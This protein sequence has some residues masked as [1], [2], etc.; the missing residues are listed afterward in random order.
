MRSA[1]EIV[2]YLLKQS[3]ES[4]ESL[5]TPLKLQKLLYYAQAWSLVIKS[6]TLFYED[7]EA[8]VHGPVIPPVYRRY[9]QYG[10]K[11][12]PQENFFSELKADEID[13]LNMVWMNYGK[14]SAKSLEELTHSE[15]PWINAR[16]G[17]RLDQLSS[18]KIS[19]RDMRNYYI[20]FIES[21]QP[22]K[23]SSVALQ[24]RKETYKRYLKNN[25]LIGVGSVLEIN[26]VSSRRLS[27]VPSDFETSLSDFESI[28]SDWEK[29][30]G[31]IQSAIDIVEEKDSTEYE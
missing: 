24:K 11:T 19:I 5:I 22:P 23:I 6:E 29:V 8:W 14:K 4:A 13:I 17:L 21:T 31:Y 1:F 7:I 10:Y 25:F 2:P 15:Y 9:K 20:Q 28:S 30:G 12:L 3:R 26:P 18:R 27:Y 16:E